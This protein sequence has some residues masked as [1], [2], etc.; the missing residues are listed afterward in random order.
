MNGAVADWQV[1]PIHTKHPEGRAY[2]LPAWVKGLFGLDYRYNDDGGAWVLTHL[3]T[4]YA[5]FAIREP[6][7]FAQTI[8]DEV[9]EWGDWNFADPSGAARFKVRLPELRTR[10]PD[11]IVHINEFPLH[12]GMVAREAVQS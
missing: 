6:L 3:P 1:G 11:S 12:H 9:A 2:V 10:Y 7:P 5:V 4:G 8:A